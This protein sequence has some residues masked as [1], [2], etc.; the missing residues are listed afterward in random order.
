[1]AA[2]PR[3]VGRSLTIGGRVVWHDAQTRQI[4]LADAYARC[5]V[6]LTHDLEST[7]APGQ[8][9][10]VEGHVQRA[11][12]V[13]VAQLGGGHILA[14][15]DGEHAGNGQF[16]RFAGGVGQNL[17]K[18][19]TLLRAVREFFDQRDF[20]EVAT[21]ARV[22]APGTDVYLAP[23]P[24]GQRW[25]ITSPE[26]HL[27][28]LVVGG[29]PR[30]YELAH[31]HRQDEAGQWHQPEFM[32]LEWYQAFL[33]FDGVITQTEELVRWLA[34]S[35]DLGPTLYVDGRT[36]SLDQPFER[37]SV[38]QAFLSFAGIDDAAHLAATDE[39]A[40][41]QAF[42]DRVEPALRE[43]PQ[44]VFLTHYPIT[45]AALAQ[46]CADDHDYAERFE[47]FVGG[48]ELCNGYGELR[49]ESVQRA[50]FEADVHRRA[51]RGLP[52]LP[53]DEG[54]LAALN[55]GLPACSG[56]ALGID[57]LVALLL[58]EPMERVVAFP[59]GP[60]C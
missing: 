43:L 30:V 19:A 52:A 42:V 56:N 8:W 44:P 47:L 7:L 55:E 33:P 22:T 1:M 26:F 35:L 48:V 51:M 2:L 10:V 3:F 59:A 36:V 41:F 20:C 5:R 24:A 53:V 6:T 32:L 17:R 50:R 25:L 12:D 54:L 49:S 37:I 38:K 23:Q 46:A 21:P 13:D 60:T 4:V 16:A 31:C 9:L 14:S 57:R 29:L 27:K 58:G 39:D 15:F 34:S 45:Q 40:Y 28:R 11:G 18:R